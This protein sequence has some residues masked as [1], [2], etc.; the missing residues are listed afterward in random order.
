M[1]NLNNRNTDKYLL[2]LAILNKKKKKKVNN[3]P[4]LIL[5]KVNN[6]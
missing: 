6:L 2:S 5:N 3:L 4:K 1:S